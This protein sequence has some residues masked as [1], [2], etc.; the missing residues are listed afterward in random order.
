[1]TRLTLRLRPAKQT[2]EPYRTLDFLA[3]IPN[4]YYDQNATFGDAFASIAG[5]S[6]RETAIEHPRYVLV[7]M[8]PSTC[9]RIT[10]SK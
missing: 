9:V 10:A 1:M 5:R 7:G 2:G 6:S 4:G 3:C 8:I